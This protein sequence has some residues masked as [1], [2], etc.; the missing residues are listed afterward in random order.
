MGAGTNRGTGTADFFR[1]PGRR[2][3]TWRGADGR[4]G[5]SCWDECAVVAVAVEATDA[6]PVTTLPATDASPPAPGAITTACWL[7][8]TVR[9]WSGA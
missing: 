5:T 3:M 7:L 4:R 2:L 9:T 1:A 8:L 6:A